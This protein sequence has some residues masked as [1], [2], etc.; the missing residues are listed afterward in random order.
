MVPGYICAHFLPA[1]CTCSAA[2]S[3]LA[4]CSQLDLA[5][6][7]DPAET[8]LNWSGYVDIR[9]P[10]ELTPLD[11]I[12]T[13]TTDM[14]GNPLDIKTLTR[15]KARLS[16]EGKKNFLGIQAQLWSETLRGPDLLEYMAFPK[17]LGLAERAWATTPGWTEI[18][19]RE[20]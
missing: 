1:D 10:F 19:N 9:K 3:S 20:E 12:K 15:E 14:Y 16:D 13:A 5:Y 11:I 18:E 6:N 7:P 17:L 8:G 4:K 2:A